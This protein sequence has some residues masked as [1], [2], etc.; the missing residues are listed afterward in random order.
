M[1]SFDIR[2]LNV[3]FSIKLATSASIQLDG[4][5]FQLPHSILP[6]LSSALATLSPVF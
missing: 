6:Y 5:V 4:S 2:F 1:P 3:S